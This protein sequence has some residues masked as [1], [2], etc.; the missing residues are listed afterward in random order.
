MQTYIHRGQSTEAHKGQLLLPHWHISHL[1]AF[2]PS[3]LQLGDCYIYCSTK[4]VVSTHGLL[5]FFDASEVGANNVGP[6]SAGVG[7]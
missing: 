4:L 5:I 6:T 1:E 3:D 2:S 7:L